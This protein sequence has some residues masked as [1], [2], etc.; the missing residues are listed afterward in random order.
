MISL[1]HTMKELEMKIQN[2]LANIAE[3]LYFLSY[4]HKNDQLTILNPI[5]EGK[6]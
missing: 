3:G 4:R 6:S 2:T 5:K 1:Q